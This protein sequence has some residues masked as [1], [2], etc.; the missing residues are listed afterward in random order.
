MPTVVAAMLAEAVK[1][2][3]GDRS[4]ADFDIA[5][6]MLH[7]GDTPEHVAAMLMATSEKV[8]KREGRRRQSDGVRYVEQT[9]R[10][11]RACKSRSE[12]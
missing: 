8:V 5:C 2:H 7:A 9:V 1:R 4:R 10:R 11:A 6:V 3:N 12:R